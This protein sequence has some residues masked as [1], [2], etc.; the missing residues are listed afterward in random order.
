MK[1]FMHNLWNSAFPGVTAL[2][3]FIITQRINNIRVTIAQR[4][5]IIHHKNT[6]KKLFITTNMVQQNVNFQPQLKD[7]YQ[8]TTFFCFLSLL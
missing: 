8:S 5:Q 2:F 1:Y 6:K 7:S 3:H 4:T